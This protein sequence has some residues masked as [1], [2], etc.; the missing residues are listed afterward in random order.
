MKMTIFKKKL[1][2]TYLICLCNV[3][4]LA[5]AVSQKVEET[6][7]SPNKYKTGSQSE[8]IQKAI[9]E[10]KN[11]TGKVVIPKYDAVAKKS[12]WLIDQ[13]I[14]LPSDFELELNNCTIKLS[15]KCR[16]NFIRSAN[17][18][19]TIKDIVPLKNIR[20]IGKGN[21]LLE[22]A[23][24]PRATGDHNKTLSLNPNGFGQSYGTDAGKPGVN[25]KG[26]WRNHA[27]ILAYTDVFEVS[28]IT[29]KDYHGHGLVLE[30]CTNGKV[31]DM[32]FNVRQAVTVDGVDKQILNQDGMGVR[33]GCK[34]I[35]IANCKGK[36]GDDFINIGL[37]DTG[38]GAGEENVNVVS[39]SIYRGEI[40]NISTIYLQ[41]WQDFYSISHR[42]IR[43]MPVGKL[44]ISNVFIENMVISPLA[45]QG[46]VVEYAEHVKGLFV[47]NLI[48]HQPIKAKGISQASFRDIIYQ[49][50]DEAIDVQQ[51]ETV[52]LDHVMRIKN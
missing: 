31:S 5:A 16:D 2:L 51:S 35:L 26:G 50:K 7:I 11:T 20:I 28:G 32:T 25:Q 34:N 1:L 9:K 22:G 17:A 23:D 52:V 48:S 19:L 41:N 30:R 15:D 47:R 39:G 49:G 4:Y 21:V 38:V 36:S 24:H 42:S 43:I 29:L 45:K 14:L 46:L 27:I 6:F 44:R 3:F 37:T 40:D 8:R 33:F 13:A 18:G 10:A 12:V